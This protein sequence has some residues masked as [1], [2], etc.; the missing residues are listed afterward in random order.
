MEKIVK[1]IPDSVNAD[2]VINEGYAMVSMPSAQQRFDYLAECGFETDETGKVKADGRAF[3]AI[4]KVLGFAKAHIK[5]V[6]FKAKDGR[7]FKN[8]EDL[9]YDM[10]GNQILVELSMKIINGFRPSPN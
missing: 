4:S 6:N 10:D 8:Y 1:L 9:D 7:V 5:E 2:S 3:K